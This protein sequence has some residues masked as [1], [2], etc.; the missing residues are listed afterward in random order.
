MK[1]QF[2][3][4][5]SLTRSL[6]LTWLLGIAATDACAQWVTPPVIAPGVQQQ[7]FHSES[8]GQ[9]VSYHIFLPPEYNA[10]GDQRFPVLYWLHGAGAGTSSIAPLCQLYA[11]AIQSKLIPPVLIV[12]PNGMQYSMWSDAVNGNVPME[13]VVIND[14]ISHVDANFRTLPR[15]Q[16]RIIEG[17]SMGGYGAARLGLKHNHLFAGISMLAAG[18]M[19]LDFLN[20]PPG[21]SMS[22]PLRLQIFQQVWASDPNLFFIQSPWNIAQQNAQQIIDASVT[23]RLA[24]GQLDFVVPPNLDFRTH[25]EELNIPHAFYFPPNIDHSPMQLL[26]ALGPQ[27]WSFY[28][29]ALAGI[30]EPEIV[31]A[32]P[33]HAAYPV[34][35]QSIWDRIDQTKYL[36]KESSVS[37]TLLL[38]NLINSKQGINGVAFEIQ[39]LSETVNFSSDDFIFQCSPTGAFDAETNPP[40]NWQAAPAPMSISVSPG[41]STRLLIEWP[42]ESIMNRWLRITLLANEKTGLEEPAIYYIGHLLGENTGPNAGFFA[43]S[44]ADVAPIRAEVGQNADASSITDIDKSGTVTFS[45]ISTMRGNVGSQ[46]PQ[47]SVP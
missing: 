3:I 1:T 41:M 5:F 10:N 47:L 17:F 39:G 42:D 34:T 22:L 38:E 7:L 24:V 44:F 19:Q 36:L 15:R 26:L 46:L 27:N 45:D 2:S 32:R 29:E 40:A 9:I 13:S 11:N 37:Q 35:G 18:P 4:I 33:Y 6:A 14:L 28:N 21:A 30:G 23:I 43:V 16:G 8:A 20:P 31:S 12:F 25:L